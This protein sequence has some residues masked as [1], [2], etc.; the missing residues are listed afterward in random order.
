MDKKFTLGDKVVVD[1]ENSSA[2][3]EFGYY[4]IFPGTCVIF[5]EGQRDLQKSYT[6]KVSSI[7]FASEEE[8]D[9]WNKMRT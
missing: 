8:L 1:N 4:Q 3:Y 9:S 2:I 5:E 7:R 6:M